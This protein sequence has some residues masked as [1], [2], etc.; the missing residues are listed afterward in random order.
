VTFFLIVG[1]PDADLGTSIDPGGAHRR[2]ASI[3]RT[4]CASAASSSRERSSGPGSQTD[5]QTGNSILAFL[6]VL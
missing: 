5:Q 6:H 2:N 4:H 1:S 3:L